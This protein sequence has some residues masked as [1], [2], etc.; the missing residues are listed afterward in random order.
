MS[1]ALAPRQRTASAAIALIRAFWLAVGSSS[2]TSGIEVISAPFGID[3]SDCSAESC[4]GTCRSTSATKASTCATLE[5]SAAISS[6]GA[7]VEPSS[8]TSNVPSGTTWCTDS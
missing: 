4:E 7:L 6:T 8:V 2:R 3:R 5:A 1:R